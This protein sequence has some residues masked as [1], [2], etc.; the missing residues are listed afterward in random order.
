MSV[1]FL[2]NGAQTWFKAGWRGFMY[3]LSVRLSNIGSPSI[4]HPLVKI[5]LGALMWLPHA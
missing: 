4:P 1:S 3:D 5:R 2:E